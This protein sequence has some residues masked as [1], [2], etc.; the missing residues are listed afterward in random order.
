M[1]LRLFGATIGSRV[2]PYP[3]ARVWAPWNLTMEDESC[4]GLDSDTYNVAKVFIGKAAV[5]SQ[6][7]Y[8]CTASH[9]VDDPSFPLTAAPIQVGSKA[10]VAAAAFV[11]PGVSIGAGAVI[12]AAS[13]VRR[14][15]EPWTIVIGNPAVRV[16]QRPNGK[17]Q[18]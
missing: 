6:K 11:G 17:A 18:H 4:L 7:V 14:D 16:R 3:T 8:L 5:I 1:L 12:G 15:V 13:V 9:D 2:H 10:W